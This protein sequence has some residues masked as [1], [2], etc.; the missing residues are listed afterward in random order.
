MFSK[1]AA[2]D[3]SKF[4]QPLSHQIRIQIVEE[5]SIGEI[6]VTSLQNKIGISQSG[7]SQHLAIL[8]GSH[9]IKERK[10]GRRVF[11]SLVAPELANWLLDGIELYKRCEQKTIN[12]EAVS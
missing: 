9:L 8:K 10:V 6:D 5:L 3:L 11:Y 2:E 7:V 12:F 4:I 1:I